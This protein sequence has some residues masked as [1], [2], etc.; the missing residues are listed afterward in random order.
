MHSPRKHRINTN[1]SAGAAR[2]RQAATSRPG[3]LWDKQQSSETARTGGGRTSA[4]AALRASSQQRHAD[5]AE[6]EGAG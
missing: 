6:T 3:Q 5:V 4:H 1:S 2:E